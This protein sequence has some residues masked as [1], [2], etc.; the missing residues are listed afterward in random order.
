VR[1]REYM[2]AGWHLI[3]RYLPRKQDGS[4]EHSRARSTTN[5]LNAPHRC[6]DRLAVWF[7]QSNGVA[8]TDDGATSFCN[9]PWHEDAATASDLECVFNDEQQGLFHDRW[10]RL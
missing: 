10:V 7:H 3:L 1:K 4:G 2:R 5:H 8:D 9:W 6:I